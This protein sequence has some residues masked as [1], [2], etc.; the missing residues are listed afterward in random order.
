MSSS[1]AVNVAPPRPSDTGP[2][3]VVA[4]GTAQI[5]SRA[6]PSFADPVSQY[7]SDAQLREPAFARQRAALGS[8]DWRA[9]F[10][11]QAIERYGVRTPDARGRSFGDPLA[12]LD[13]ALGG[14]GDDD[15]ALDF[16]WAIRDGG[17]VA[18]IVPTT[19]R[20]VAALRPGGLGIV[21]FPFG[22]GAALRS[23][24]ERIAIGLI[25]DRHAVAVL[26]FRGA[27][28]SRIVPFALI[29]GRG[30]DA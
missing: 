10:V 28:P 23:D 17:D 8:D 26:K 5:T 14:A 30:D 11:V 22:D 13:A 24:V 21:I 7:H 3:G 9:A 6:A 4:L 12:P 25:A 27:D 15:G 19:A 1:I 16:A 2:G 20:M 29:F 18:G